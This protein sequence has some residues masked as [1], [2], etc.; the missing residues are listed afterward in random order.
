[1]PVVAWSI[2]TFGW[3]A[4]AFGSGHHRDPGR[5][6]ARHASSAAARRTTARRSTACRSPSPPDGNWRDQE[7]RRDSRLHGARSAAHAGVLADLARPRAFRCS[8]CTR[9]TC[10]PSRTSR[11]AWAT[12][13]RRPTLVFT[14]VTLRADRRRGGR[15]GDRRPIREAPD[16]RGLHADARGRAADAHLRR[17][18]PRRCRGRRVRVLHGTAWGLRGPFM[19]AIR[20]DYFGRTRDRHD[21][22]AVVPDHRVRPDRRA[23]DRRR[24]SPTGPATTA[25]DS[26]CSRCSPGWGRCSSSPQR[27]PRGR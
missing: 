23:D 14:L 7:A 26:R 8:S 17:T 11:K 22:R 18:R 2:Q 9:S 20:A 27:S 12:R 16:L 5:L 3:R 19:Q 6:A 15:L 10:T 25:P 13:S 1:M 24:R 21:H 4:T